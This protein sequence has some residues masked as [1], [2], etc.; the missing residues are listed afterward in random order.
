VSI[1]TGSDAVSFPDLAA[2]F[3]VQLNW[4]RGWERGYAV[5]ITK[6]CQSDYQPVPK[7]SRS[8]N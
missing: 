6:S 1:K 7:T 2:Y 4:A 5:Q 8:C 3:R